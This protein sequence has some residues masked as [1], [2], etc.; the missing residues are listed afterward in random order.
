MPAAARS[1]DPRRVAA[2]TAPLRGLSVSPEDRLGRALLATGFG[3][4]AEV[5]AR[6]A[7][8]LMRVLPVV[9]DIRRI[10]SAALDLVRVADGSVDAYAESGLNA[11]DL[12]AGWLIVEEA[13]WS[14]GG[15]ARPARR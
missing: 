2:E 4:A 1:L 11:W 13:G 8:I 9:R 7:A 6:Q 3:Y 15:A 5:R 10:G 12:A 14:W